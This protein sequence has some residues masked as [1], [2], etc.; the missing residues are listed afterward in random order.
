MT[1]EE[2]HSEFISQSDLTSL[3]G[4]STNYFDWHIPTSFPEP[5]RLKVGSKSY[6]LYRISDIK[7][8]KLVE[9]VL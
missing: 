8:N 4:K 2:F 6:K 1:Q 7:H 9:G 3:I 5:L